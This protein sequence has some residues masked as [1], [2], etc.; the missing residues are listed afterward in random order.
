MQRDSLLDDFFRGAYERR[1]LD[2]YQDLDRAG[3][4]GR[5]LS[6][7]YTPAEDDPRRPAMLE[8]LDRLFAEHQTDG[9]VRFEYDTEIYFRRLARQS[10]Q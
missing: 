3:L 6:S 10:S 7:S 8:V 4:H 1:I 9:M 2:N 5:V